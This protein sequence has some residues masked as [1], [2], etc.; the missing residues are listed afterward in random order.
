MVLGSLLLGMAASARGLAVQNVV[1][2]AVQPRLTLT[3]V[4]P[5]IDYLVEDMRIVIAKPSNLLFQ[6]QS[7]LSHEVIVA[8]MPQMIAMSNRARHA[9][10]RGLDCVL[11]DGVLIHRR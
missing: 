1:E 4:A 9:I 2:A 5:G 7:R 10:A 8:G 11:A 6:A 3:I